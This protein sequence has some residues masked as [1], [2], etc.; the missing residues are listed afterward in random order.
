MDE[1]TSE[2]GTLA[3]RALLWTSARYVAA[4]AVLAGA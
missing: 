4:E 2:R 3:P 1:G